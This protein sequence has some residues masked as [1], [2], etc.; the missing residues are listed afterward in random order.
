MDGSVVKTR[1][2]EGASRFSYVVVGEVVGSV[3]VVVDVRKEE[4]RCRVE[5]ITAF[6]ASRLR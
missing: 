5:M 3:S 2:D 4:R 1:K 6:Q